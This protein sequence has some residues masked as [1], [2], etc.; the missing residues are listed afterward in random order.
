[1]TK[2][3]AFFSD[4]TIQF[5]IP[6][7]PRTGE[8]VVLRFRTPTAGVT[9][10]CVELEA[11]CLPMQRVRETPLF[12]YYE[13]TLPP[14]FG[15]VSYAFRCVWENK[16]CYY[17]RQGLTEA[18]PPDGRFQ[19]IPGWTPPEW[20]RGA[21]FYQI[22]PDRFR[23]GDPEN[24]V[25]TGDYLYLDAPVR[26]AAWEEPVAARDGG[27]F[28]GGDL[29]GILDKLPYLRDLGVEALYLNPIFQSPSSHKYDIQD[30]AHIDPHLGTDALFADL[31][32]AA[33]AMG[34]RVVLDG[35]FN[36]CGGEHPWLKAA[37][38]NPQS[39][40]RTFFTWTGADT[41]EGWWGYKNHPKL[42]YEGAPALVER[43]MGIAEK[44]LLPPFKA[45]GWRLDVAADLGHSPA[46]NHRFWQDFRRRVKQ[47]NPQALILA[48]HYGDGTA[49]LSGNEWDSV[50]NY[51]GF[52]EPVSWYFTGMEKHSDG[53]DDG[54]KA[55]A[56]YFAAVLR[57]FL[58]K[59][60]RPVL[61]LSM[62]E[63]SNHD[64]SR[65]L[66]RTGGVV[67]RLGEADPEAN[68][69][70]ALMRAA[71]VFQ[72]TWIGCPTVYYGDEAGLAGFTD[73][74]NRRPYPWGKEDA[75]MLAF[76]RAA[77][78]LRRRHPVFKAGSL[79]F[80][81][82]TGTVFAFGRFDDREA[83]AVVLNPGDGTEQVRLPLWAMG[84][85]GTVC[86]R[87]LLTDASG[88]TLDEAEFALENGELALTVPPR[89]AMVFAV[90]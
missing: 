31:T 88:F 35:V 9:Q 48:E 13:V 18:L 75:E 84:K 83:L 34:I 59:H 1:M 74:D 38:A 52:L 51:D 57:R 16:R 76:H 87:L 21:V 68:L 11:Q 30:Y 33:H 37:L 46:Y 3:L 77:I 61:E 58:N 72:M 49:W 5:Q 26:R 81:W 29:Q 56:P 36:H 19:M 23:N 85:D 65:F 17:G 7:F 78:A 89:C 79:L 71:V 67:G 44:W 82:E 32:A 73:P 4:E 40:Y 60:S 12:A 20:A 6:P 53:R 28:Y 54:K 90:A 22:F 41:Y 63:L 66:T 8:S 25:R 2:E 39:P 47:A 69:C 62:N 50:M 14:V 43:I 70:P 80:L 10:V 42:N 24:D 27:T 15:S 55:N 45:D 86:R 64:H